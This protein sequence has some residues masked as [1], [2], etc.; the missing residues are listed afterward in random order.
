M[1]V[2]QGRIA[3]GPPWSSQSKSRSRPGRKGCSAHDVAT[4]R[5]MV[6]MLLAGSLGACDAPDASRQTTRYVVA[7]D[8][9]A[10]APGAWTPLGLQIVEVPRA[11]QKAL[12]VT[13]GVMVTKVRGA[14]RRSRILP[15]DVIVGVNQTPV[16]GVEEFNKVVAAQGHGTI[17]LLVRRAEAD[18]YIALEVGANGK[19]AA[20][21]RDPGFD[22]ED[23]SR[24]A[25]APTPEES[26]KAGRPATGKPLRT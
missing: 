4:V 22:P 25:G 26:F 8:E 2:L 5:L 21:E 20:A 24:G 10:G 19:E 12:G 15:G 7:L 23:A 18:L 17:G 6:L 1:Q 13:D 3:F 11:A 9:R 16:S 14:A